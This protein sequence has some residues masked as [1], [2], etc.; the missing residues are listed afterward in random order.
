MGA[1]DAGEISAQKARQISGQQSQHKADRYLVAA[2]LDVGKSNQQGNQRADQ[3]GDGDA[4]RD[5]HRNIQYAGFLRRPGGGESQD[6]GQRQAAIQRQIDDAGAFGD[7]FAQAG[8]DQRRGCADNAAERVQKFFVHR[9]FLISN[10][11][12]YVGF[13]GLIIVR[14]LREKDLLRALE[15]DDGQDQRPLQHASQR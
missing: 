5:L 3:H 6:S 9:V 10:S 15:E 4:Q 8:D 2:Q 12:S 1:G 13:V 14:R 7:G 11:R